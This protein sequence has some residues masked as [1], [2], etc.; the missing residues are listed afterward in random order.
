MREYAHIILSLIS[1]IDI[2]VSLLRRKGLLCSKFI[3][4]IRITISIRSL[5]EA[6]KRI[7]LV[8]YDSKE[9][10]LLIIGYIVFFGWAGYRLFRGT[11]EGSAF[12]NTL[13]E[14]CW[15]L[16]IL[17]TTANFPDVMLPTYNTN[18]VYVLFFVVYLVMGLYF[19]MNLLLAVFYSNYKNRVEQSIN[20]YEDVRENYLL[21]KFN[22]YDN[23]KGYLTKEEC[24]RLVVYLMTLDPAHNE[25]NIDVEKFVRILDKDCDGQI[26]Q[27]EFYRYFDV[28]DMMHF[29]RQEEHHMRVFPTFRSKLKYWI[30][31]PIYDMII[32]FILIGN[33]L[34]LF[35]RDW[36]DT[37][38]AEKKDVINWII[39]QI[40]INLFFLLELLA[41]YI[42]D[43]SIKKSFKKNSYKAEMMYQIINFV[44][45]FKFFVAD[46]FGVEN[47]L[48]ELII[49][50][51]ALRV[52]KILKE[53]RQWRIILQTI[54]A[55][56]GP[57]YTLVL[58]QFLLYYFFT[59][60]G[61]RLFGGL[62][63]Y[64][65]EE[66]VKDQS[67]PNIY[68]IMNFND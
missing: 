28:M 51:R 30:K 52:L 16:L 8:M 1:V 5:R 18:T 61:D 6:V 22:D 47:R 14:S 9:I 44:L 19:L 36:Y 35:I 27:T 66:I 55:L 11:Q 12:F 67:I 39:V 50:F 21:S 53:I 38:G 40:T 2:I 46:K 7:F 34:M 54:D 20:K 15:N 4:L 31:N 56:L 64:D 58:V 59:I 41:V 10:L 32:Y 62:V 24:S 49:L 43:G 3:R 57:F 13:P 26:T 48:L 37:Y 68:V 25:E 60:L 29:H 63:R 23:G 65:T 42:I 17:M 33:L 45:M